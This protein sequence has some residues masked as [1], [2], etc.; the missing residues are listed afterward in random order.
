MLFGV[1]VCD[2][3]GD[4][5]FFPHDFTFSHTAEKRYDLTRKKFKT[6]ILPVNLIELGENI[7]D[8][9]QSTLYLV[10]PRETASQKIQE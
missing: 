7:M 5:K 9:S 3:G 10:E 4:V 6:I 2:I 8:E 1:I